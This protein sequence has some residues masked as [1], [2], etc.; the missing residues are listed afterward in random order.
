MARGKNISRTADRCTVRR[1][2]RTLFH[3]GATA[4]WSANVTIRIFPSD[5]SVGNDLPGEAALARG[6]YV[7]QKKEKGGKKR[8]EKERIAPSGKKAGNGPLLFPNKRK[9]I[10]LKTAIGKCDV[11]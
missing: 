3:R 9:L 1:H 7:F 5:E 11:V 8:K 6:R 10:F 2:P 4:S